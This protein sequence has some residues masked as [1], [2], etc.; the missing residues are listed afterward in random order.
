MGRPAGARFGEVTNEENAAAVKLRQAGE[1][2]EKKARLRSAIR[3]NP[4]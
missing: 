2:I 4:Q 1:A 3:V